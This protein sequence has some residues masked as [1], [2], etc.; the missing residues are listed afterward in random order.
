MQYSHLRIHF[1]EEVE[2]YVKR[3]SHGR[4]EELFIKTCLAGA[5]VAMNRASG[6]DTG[7]GILSGDFRNLE[8]Q[9]YGLYS[10]GS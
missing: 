2:E 8:M 6:W 10:K 5:N 3:E 9:M 1:R 7:R 4:N